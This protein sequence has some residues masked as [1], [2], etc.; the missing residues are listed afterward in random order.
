MNTRT[1]LPAL[2]LT[3]S[4][5]AE[6]G[7]PIILSEMEACRGAELVVIATLDAPREAPEDNPGEDDPFGGSNWLQYGFTHV[8]EIR[9]AEEV[10]GK[11]PKN[12]RV[13]GGKLNAGTHYR[14]E[15]G[16][17]L[18]LL[19]RV[20]KGAYRAVDWHYSFM[21]LKEGKVGWLVDRSSK[22]REWITPLQVARRIEAHQKNWDDELPKRL[23]KIRLKEGVKFDNVR[24]D[25]AFAQLF[26][27]FM[28]IDPEEGVDWDFGM[29]VCIVLPFEQGIDGALDDA[30]KIS[31][32]GWK[33]GADAWTVFSALITRAGWHWS[34]DGSRL[35][36]FAW[37]KGRGE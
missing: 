7:R 32:P 9:V 15:E 13:Y 35:S 34:Y 25:R 14:L 31:D 20:E 29:R 3:F 19:T 26:A 2:L 24:A 6:A 11:A 16:K 30:R 17:Y 18:L 1:I 8:S 10:I 5:V 33:A 37:H 36:V 23:G 27:S 21:P 4:G 12:L 22:K 28:K